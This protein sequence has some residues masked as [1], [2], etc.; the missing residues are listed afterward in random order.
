MNMK[1]VA[2]TSAAVVAGALC[3]LACVDA[4]AP[5]DNATKTTPR[6]GKSPSGAMALAKAGDT[7]TADALPAPEFIPGFAPAPDEDPWPWAGG[8]LVVVG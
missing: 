4:A 7:T 6:A 2:R 3:V 5:V 8:Q 1:R